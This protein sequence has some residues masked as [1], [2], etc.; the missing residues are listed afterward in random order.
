MKRCVFL[1]FQMY[2]MHLVCSLWKFVIEIW[3]YW[4]IQ[5]IFSWIIYKQAM[6]HT[7]HQH[8]MYLNS[9]KIKM[10]L[11]GLLLTKL[12]HFQQCSFFHNFHILKF[13]EATSNDSGS[14][15]NWKICVISMQI[16]NKE[17]RGNWFTLFYW[18]CSFEWII[19]SLKPFFIS[20]NHH[21]KVVR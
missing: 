3:F 9:H 5:S 17:K 10:L 4:A 1:F 12:S 15:W 11:V 2:K 16:P 20:A 18:E 14:N 19:N 7:V 6:M 8:W 21:I 13:T